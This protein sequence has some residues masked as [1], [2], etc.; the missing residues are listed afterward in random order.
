M[1]YTTSPGHKLVKVPKF[2]LVV[3][4]PTFAYLLLSFVILAIAI[5][6]P[7]N[8]CCSVLLLECCVLLWLFPSHLFFPLR[9][10]RVSPR[11]P[12][13]SYFFGL[14]SL[15]MRLSNRSLNTTNRAATIKGC[16][17]RTLGLALRSFQA[18][19]LGQHFYQIEAS[20]KGFCAT[21]R[22]VLLFLPSSGTRTL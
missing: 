7:L 3:W 4:L 8:R 2:L 21:P 15:F 1:F 9:T 10:T 5:I 12:S 22:L 6:Y 17:S 11:T 20:C 13:T 16:L 18:A 19:I 14:F